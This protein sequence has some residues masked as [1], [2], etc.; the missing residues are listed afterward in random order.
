MKDS[1]IL[2]LSASICNFASLVAEGKENMVKRVWSFQ[3]SAQ[4]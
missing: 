4:K 3:A 1:K 2:Q